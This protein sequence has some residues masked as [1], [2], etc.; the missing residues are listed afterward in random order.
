MGRGGEAWGLD[1]YEH[2]LIINPRGDALPRPP[3]CRR[4]A[5]GPAM[6]VFKPAGIPT[7]E[8]RQVAMT[9]DEYEALRLAAAT[10]HPTRDG[11]MM[12]DYSSQA[13][14][15]RKGKHT[16]SMEEDLFRGFLLDLRDLDVDIML[17]IK[18]KEASAGRA[19]GILRDVG[20][21]AVSLPAAR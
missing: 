3:C 21:L 9:L 1:N 2:M 16:A 17:E 14:G 8:L 20:R 18:A 19:C 11:V 4:I 15:E 10:W 12:M 5:A 6:A 13:H 7:R